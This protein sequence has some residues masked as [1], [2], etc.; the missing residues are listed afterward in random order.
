MPEKTKKDK[1]KI[2]RFLLMMSLIL[3][4]ELLKASFQDSS[5]KIKPLLL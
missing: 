3:L 1:N 4:D 2:G 5:N